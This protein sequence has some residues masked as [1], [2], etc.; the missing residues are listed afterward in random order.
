MKSP[1]LLIEQQN[2]WVREYQIEKIGAA[3]KNVRNAMSTPIHP[4]RRF[5]R[6]VCGWTAFRRSCG[7][8]GAASWAF[9]IDIETPFLGLLASRFKAAA[10]VRAKAVRA[11]AA[12]AFLRVAL[13]AV[14]R[15][16]R[17]ARSSL[18]SSTPAPLR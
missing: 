8:N 4:K 12:H 17:S 3:Q 7:S 2:Q 6:S 9:P 1:P 15:A 10:D 13:S 16:V 14:S 11:S 5:V 18:Q